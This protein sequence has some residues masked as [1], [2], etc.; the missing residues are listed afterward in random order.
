MMS[1]TTD[2]R[3]SLSISSWDS[4]EIQ[5]RDGQVTEEIMKRMCVSLYLHKHPFLWKDDA[6]RLCYLE[7]IKSIVIK[8]SSD[9]AFS[10]AT[11]IA[12]ALAFAIK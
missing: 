6:Y 9:D 8:Y 7:R 4:L 10:N 12:S 5:N 3:K 1:M 11:P 2:K